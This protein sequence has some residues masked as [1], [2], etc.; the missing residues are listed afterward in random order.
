[1]LAALLA[2]AGG[3]G[4]ST[5][6]ARYPIAGNVTYNGQPVPAGFI[7]FV[8][9]TAKGNSGPA[10]GAPIENGRYATPAG[11]GTAGGPHI[12]TVV[13]QDGVPFEGPEGRVE[14]GQGLFPAHV[15]HMDLPKASSTQDFDVPSSP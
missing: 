11:Q 1:M 3:C 14:A 6:P 8:P 5:D 13:G 2:G 7:H 4:G 10:A 9:D 12:I 15:F